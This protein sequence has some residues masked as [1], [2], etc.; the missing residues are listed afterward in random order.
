MIASFPQTTCQMGH[1]G[2]P[3]LPADI[4]SRQTYHFI[5]SPWNQ[6]E[7]HLVLCHLHYTPVSSQ[8]IL[9]IG[10]QLFWS[11]F[12]ASFRHSIYGIVSYNMVVANQPWVYL[13]QTMIILEC[14]DLGS[15]AT[16]NSRH[17]AYGN[18]G[19]PTE[20]LRRL[21]I[22]GCQQ[23]FSIAIHGSPAFRSCS[24]EHVQ[25]WNVSSRTLGWWFDVFL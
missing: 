9:V 2:M 8:W 17:P 11:I 3:Q 7:I 25:T 5:P 6:T 10:I 14:L 19:T 13:N 1:I 24:M 12:T 18:Y 23:P 16:S 4:L 21:N 15:T 22:Q 20:S